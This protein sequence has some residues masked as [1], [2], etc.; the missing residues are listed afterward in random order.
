MQKFWV[1]W[2][3]G[4]KMGK[5][6]KHNSEGEA[7][8]EARRLSQLPENAGKRVFPLVATGYYQIQAPVI[9]HEWSC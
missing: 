6:K 5:P 7:L 2:V 1:C 8:T 4:T 3:E 9:W